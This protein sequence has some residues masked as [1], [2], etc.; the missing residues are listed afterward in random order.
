VRTTVLAAIV[1]LG[2]GGADQETFLAVTNEQEGALLSAWVASDGTAYLAGGVFGGGRGLLLR[3]DGRNVTAIPTPDAHAFWWIHGVGDREMWLAGESGEV[4]SFDGTTVTRI[5]AGA[6]P[7][8]I[9]FGIWGASGDDLWA[10]GGS[11]VAGGPRQVVRRLAGGSWTPV[12]SP[13]EVDPATT[14]FK[15]WGASASD[16]WIVGEG[17]VIL[18]DR[19]AGLARVAAPGAEKYLTVHGCRDSEVLAVGGGV[20]GAALRFDG[21]A[22]TSIPLLD[23]P[24]LGGVACAAGG[25]YVG[26]FF[27]YAA[28]VQGD[29]LR[30]VSTPV[31]VQDLAIHGIAVGAGRVMAVGGDLLA[32]GA[33][34]RRGFALELRR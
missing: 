14:Y 1:V 23:V 24:P 28:R 7:E 10:V 19:G 26:G 18:R 31:Q 13:P 33:Q 22:W 34:P 5:D 2:C 15:V 16:V 6:P 20:A 21:A 30:V 9:L 8:S 12:T 29:S 17:G 27:G 25:A 4:H 3:W 11:F 32:T